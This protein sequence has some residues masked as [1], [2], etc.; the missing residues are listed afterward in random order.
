[1]AQPTTR[2]EFKDYVLRKI[3]APVIQIYQ[4]SY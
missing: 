1:M 3:G 2:S 4:K